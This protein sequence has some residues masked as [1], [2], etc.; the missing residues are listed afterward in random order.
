M[1]IA[2]IGTDKRVQEF[3]AAFGNLHEI[4]RIQEK[5]LPNEDL[6]LYNAIFDLNYENTPE[7]LPYYAPLKNR[8]VVISAVRTTLQ[9]E[10]N[11]I[12]EVKC[13]L[14]GMNCMPTFIDRPIIECTVADR[15]DRDTWFNLG[16]LLNKKVSIVDDR[17]GMV[18]PRVVCMIINEAF[19]TLQ[20][21]TATIAD[22]D[23]GMKLGVNYP[24]GPFE[25]AKK[26]GYRE[27][28]QVLQAV[29]DD[30]CDDRY[31]ISHLLKQYALDHKE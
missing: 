28:Y 10:I 17:V 20:E 23:L 25:W 5:E 18:T 27:V 13:A 26:I 8:P 11:R 3:Q 1:R 29:Y 21:G 2:L 30:L 24:F 16:E 15:S 31:K 19:F 22:I 12:G 7:H 14:L 9:R 6:T 4:V